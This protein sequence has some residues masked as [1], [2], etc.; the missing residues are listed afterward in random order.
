MSA[1]IIKRSWS[2]I[3]SPVINHHLK[4]IQKQLKSQRFK[5]QKNKK[6]KKW[7]S[8]ATFLPQINSARKGSPNSRA[9]GSSSL[10]RPYFFSEC[11]NLSQKR[12]KSIKVKRVVTEHVNKLT[13]E[14]KAGIY[15]A[16]EW[17]DNVK[18]G[19]EILSSKKSL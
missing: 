8:C 9:F 18:F 5:S 4:D 1:P 6:K 15:A 13:H 11:G 2:E 10:K 14:E 19:K 17:V 3:R 16:D 7:R 12:F